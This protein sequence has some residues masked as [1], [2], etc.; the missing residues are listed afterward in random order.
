MKLERIGSLCFFAAP[1]PVVFKREGFLAIV[2][3]GEGHLILNGK[4]SIA[5]SDGVFRIPLRLLRDGENTLS[6]SSKE[7]SLRVESIVKENGAATPVGISADDALR[8]AF[9]EILRLRGALNEQAKDVCA[10][11]EKTEKLEKSKKRTL[12]S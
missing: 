9:G 12:F 6:L 2:Y 3:A 11:K 4:H 5:L 8:L 7:G 10:L 1:T